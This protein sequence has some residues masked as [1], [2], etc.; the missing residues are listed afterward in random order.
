MP[1]VPQSKPFLEGDLKPHESDLV[2]LRNDN[3]GSRSE[4]AK[5]IVLRYLGSL[6]SEGT[7]DFD[8]MVEDITRRYPFHGDKPD[9][10]RD[11]VEALKRDGWL[12]QERGILSLDKVARVTRRYL[13][14][15]VQSSR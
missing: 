7:V 9:L 13:L 15:P 8:S 6:P 3:A 12:K 1:D 11:A 2:D 10:F 5:S 4:Q 14:R